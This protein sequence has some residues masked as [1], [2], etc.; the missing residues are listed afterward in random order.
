MDSA[1]RDHKSE[2]NLGL[3]ADGTWEEQAIAE[4]DSAINAW[5]DKIPDHRTSIFSS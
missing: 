2:I 5:R 3:P 4:L 1:C